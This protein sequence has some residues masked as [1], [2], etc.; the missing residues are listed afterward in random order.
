MNIVTGKINGTAHDNV[1][2]I[3]PEINNNLMKIITTLTAETGK[4]I[5]IRP[6]T[7]NNAREVGKIPY[8]ELYEFK[9][10]RISFDRL[11]L[12]PLCRRFKRD[13]SSR[14]GLSCRHC[15]TPSIYL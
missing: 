13:I 3:M 9:K 2:V 10:I 1:V 6:P 11:R 14:L 8:L 7:W 12:R 4:L 15:Y 5:V